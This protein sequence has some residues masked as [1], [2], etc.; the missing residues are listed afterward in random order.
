[1][2]TSHQQ[3]FPN[4]FVSNINDKTRHYIE[5]QQNIKVFPSPDAVRAVNNNY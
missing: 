1:M 4:S 2:G 5:I 3:Y